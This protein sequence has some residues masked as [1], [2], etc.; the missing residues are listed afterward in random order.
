MSPLM[1][2]RWFYLL[3]LLAACGAKRKRVTLGQSLASLPEMGATEDGGETQGDAPQASGDT[4]EFET[5]TPVPE[6]QVVETAWGHQRL[7][8]GILSGPGWLCH[9]VPDVMNETIAPQV[10]AFMRERGLL[11][12]YGDVKKAIANAE[13][14][15]FKSW[16]DW[17]MDREMFSTGSGPFSEKHV[18][19][20][21]TK[22]HRAFR[23]ALFKVCFVDE[24]SDPG[25]AVRRSKFRDGHY[26]TTTCHGTVK[27]MPEGVGARQLYSGRHRNRLP[28]DVYKILYKRGALDLYME[29]SNNLLAR[30]KRPF[31]SRYHVSEN[32]WDILILETYKK[33]FAEKDVGIYLNR[34]V[35][36]CRDSEGNYRTYVY[37]WIE[38][39]DQ[40]VVGR[41]YNS[42]TNYYI[43][44]G[45][46]KWVMCNGTPYVV[47]IATEAGFQDKI[48][49]WG[50]EQ[51]AGALQQRFTD[52]PSCKCWGQREKLYCGNDIVAERK[53]NLDSIMQQKSQCMR[54]TM[55]CSTK[56]RK[57]TT[58][59]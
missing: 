29:Y 22:R 59:A 3:L 50:C 35:S 52:Y 30:P 16:K 5:G 51:A 7:P 15:A 45:M 13:K 47:K 24:G 41:N 49:K 12:A 39:T 46:V 32:R 53:F 10:E 55:Y 54:G 36:Q 21:L 42:G 33:R 58:L 23:R 20:F 25:E 57:C 14:G 28:T 38:F 31:W 18:D 11:D 34:R 40:T 4:A 1:V 27:W 26:V 48:P 9:D 17:A 56:R 37:W 2:A 8:T 44:G 6:E 19:L 43:D